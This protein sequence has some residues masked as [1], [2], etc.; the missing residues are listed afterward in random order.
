M[1]EDNRMWSFWQHLAQKCSYQPLSLSSNAMLRR[2]KH[3]AAR[4]MPSNI[5]YQIFCP[6]NLHG[7]LGKISANVILTLTILS[8]RRVRRRRDGDCCNSGVLVKAWN[9]LDCLVC[10][11]LVTFTAFKPTQ[12]FWDHILRLLLWDIKQFKIGTLGFLEELEQTH[13]LHYKWF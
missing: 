2:L 10:K 13:S 11:W 4:Q 12:N 8:S 5:K 7:N 9:I 6:K 1:V 3:Y